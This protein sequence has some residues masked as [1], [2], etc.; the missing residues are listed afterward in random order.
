MKIAT[1]VTA[2]VLG[3]APAL[4]APVT[5]GQLNGN[6]STGGADFGQSFTLTASNGFTDPAYILN[7]ASFF[8]GLPGVGGSA[9]L[10]LDVYADNG[11]GTPDFDQTTIVGANYIGSSTTSANTNST[12]EGE[13][14]AVNF[15]GITLATGTKYF[16]VFSSDGVEGNRIGASTRR[17]VGGSADSAFNYVNFDPTDGAPLLGGDEPNDTGGLGDDEHQFTVT[18][19]AVP[20]PTIALGG[21]ACLSLIGLRR[22]K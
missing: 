7:S 17:V 12:A 9:T 16:L 15:S 4:A 20:E 10:F 2:L 5:L 14:L 19:T 8:D 1:F 11:L 21:L 6:N 22:R 3:A 18:V 13:E